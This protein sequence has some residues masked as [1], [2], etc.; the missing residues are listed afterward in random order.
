M[1]DPIHDIFRTTSSRLVVEREGL[2][3]RALGSQR[4]RTRLAIGRESSHT[5]LPLMPGDSVSMGRLR[6]GRNELRQT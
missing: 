4:L 1:R 6:A 3:R 2:I 5:P